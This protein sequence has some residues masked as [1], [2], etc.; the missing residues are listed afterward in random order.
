MLEPIAILGV[1]PPWALGVLRC[2]PT[3]DIDIGYDRDRTRI[4]RNPSEEIA[5][6][7]EISADRQW[8]S[9]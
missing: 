3:H 7:P 9:R 5:G 4:D 8:F 1:A 6:F 2:R